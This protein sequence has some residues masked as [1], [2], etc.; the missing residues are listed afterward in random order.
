MKTWF[1]IVLTTIGILGLAKGVYAQPP[2]KAPNVLI[3]LMDDVGFGQPS[4]FGGPVE[5]PTLDKL[6]EG[7]LRFNN[8][9]STAVCS[10][11]RASLLSGRN[12]HAVGFGN[13]AGFQTADPGYRAQI[14]ASAASLAKILGKEGYATWMIGKWDQLPMAHINENGPFDNWPS[15]QGFDYFYG[16]LYADMDHFAPVLWRNHTPIEPARGR[17]GYNLTVDMA[18]QAIMR[19]REHERENP[20]KPFLLYFASGAG[21]AP[22]HAP[23]EFIEHYKGRFEAGWGHERERILERQKAQGLVPGDV[24]LPPWPADFPRWDSLE[25][26]AR[27]IAERSMEVFAAQLSQTD[28]EFGRIVAE[29]ERSGELENTVIIV[30]SDNG[31]SA[32]GGVHGTF[33]EWR[34]SNGLQTSIEENLQHLDAWGGPS[35]YPEYPA[36]WAVAG[37]TPFRY[38]KTQV[39]FGGVREPMIIH[40]PAGIRA[41]GEVRSQF[42][43]LNDVMPTL[44]DLAGIEPPD[45]VDGVEQQRLDGVSMRY[46]FDNAE[47]PSRHPLQYFELFGNRAIV[48]NGWKAV[49][50]HRKEPWEFTD[51]K[52][53]YEDDQWELYHLDS[54]F[55]ELHDLADQYPEKL[56]ELTAIFDREARRN[57]VYPLTPDFASYQAGKMRD[58]LEANGGRFVYRP[59]EFRRLTNS[60]GAPPVSGIPNF[61]LTA[62]L[63]I[64]KE[65]AHGVVVAEGGRMGGYVLHFQGGVPVFSYNYVGSTTT[66][67][68]GD[69]V[70]QPG[71]QQVKVEFRETAGG[72]ARVTMH[73]QG[74]PVG[75]GRIDRLVPHMFQ[76][77]DVFNLGFDEGSHVIEGYSNDHVYTGEIEKVVFEFMLR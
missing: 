4:A 32:A 57:N 68:R 39:H 17:D 62:D 70:L 41:A 71:P 66:H 64:P 23:K 74:K 63:Q 56:E 7:G 31:A 14:P 54:D 51:N 34:F 35:T 48:A 61:D 18:D 36:G 8:F 60:S 40:W 43:H 65:P 58:I 59:G 42:H 46:A 49:V 73:A 45:V 55:N 29:L 72:G 3:W 67:I 75:S 33:N 9:H 22:H 52:I 37:N 20:E 44:L 1:V 24:K 5:T 25:R 16:F 12:H 26:D 19:I 47:A 10:S 27:R 76:G 21:H 50:V 69:R 28:Q 2:Q 6:A 30:T 53:P 15:G 11:S 13:H 38:Y 77:S